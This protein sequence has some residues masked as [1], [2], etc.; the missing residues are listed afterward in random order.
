MLQKL[1]ES[2]L[3]VGILLV[4]VGLCFL[5]GLSPF[6]STLFFNFLICCCLMIFGQLLFLQGA[7][8]SLV[9]VGKHTGSALMKIGKVW[10]ILLFG[11]ILGFVT[12][13]AEPDVQVLAEL[14]SPSGN[15]GFKLLFTVVLGLGVASLTLLAYTRILKNISIKY[16]ML[17]IYVL[18]IILAIFAPQEQLILAFDSS[19]TT[20]G[21]ITVP[22]LLALTVGIC[23]V[24]A[25]NKKED[26][27]GVVGIATTGS[28]FTFILLSYFLPS[29]TVELG[30]TNNTYLNFLFSSVVDVALALLPLF[31]IFIVLQIVYFKFPIKY[32][33]G[34]LSGYFL[35]AVGL[36]LFLSAV[37]FGFAPL[38]QYLG[39]T[40]S[41]PLILL[42]LS[43]CLGVGLVFTEPSIKVLLAQMEDVSSGL[44]K[45]R[46]VYLAL[47]MAVALSLVMATIRT[48]F[49]FSFWWYLIP[50]IVCAVTLLFFTPTLF[51][52][53]AFDSGGVVAG[54]ILTSFVLPFYIGMSNQFYGTGKG[55]L[56]VIA[57]VTF[58]PVIAI[59]ILG[60]IYQFVQH[61]HQRKIQQQN[62]LPQPNKQVQTSEQAQTNQTQTNQTQPLKEEK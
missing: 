3:G 54:T 22:F 37:L 7:E 23:H 6:D 4:M 32:L 58:M 42:L 38:G 18:L 5:F 41:S 33:F 16:V 26:N 29:Q 8:N 59:E 28:I 45:K 51:G 17:G 57:I 21:A 14:L 39:Q 60:I 11:F 49:N 55:A 10:L 9:K 56:G 34:I 2:S 53:I 19:G 50:L 20:T 47:C 44:I 13:V 48:Y 52:A 43:I 46:Y 1:K 27:F 36:V 40:I 62:T 24:R 12:T 30:V 15:F 35:T 31:I 25:I 61:K